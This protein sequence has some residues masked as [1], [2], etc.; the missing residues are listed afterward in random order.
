M[1]IHR[2]APEDA[3]AP[4]RP[5][6]AAIAVLIHMDRVLLV[7]RANP[8]DRG[9]WGFPGGRIEAGETTEACATRE[10][11]EETGVD[12]EAVRVLTVVDAFDRDEEERL[13]HHFVLIAVLCRWVGG[14]AIAGDDALEARWLDVDGLE[15]AGLELSR[16]V[17]KVARQAMGPRGPAD[18]SRNTMVAPGVLDHVSITVPDLAAAEAFYDAALAALG[19]AKAG[20]DHADAWIAYGPRCDAGHPER[21]YFSIRLGPEPETSPRRH[22]CFKA[23]DRSAVEAFWKA[24]LLHGGTDNGAPGLRAAY[25]PS[26]Y[27]A[28]LIDPAGNRVE[29]VCH[30]DD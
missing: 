28:F 3:D 18:G 8:P 13:R 9:L 7:R 5:I 2:P 21:T 11:R 19:I 16:D 14:E 24:G 30:H 25:H 27:A 10:L 1:P 20:S 26:Y 22:C 4:L 23:S 29:A 15:D 6:A 12:A 17:A